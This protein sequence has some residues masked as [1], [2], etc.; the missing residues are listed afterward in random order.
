MVRVIEGKRKSWGG[1]EKKYS[2]SLIYSERENRKRKVIKR[3]N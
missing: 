2:E 3:I 1:I